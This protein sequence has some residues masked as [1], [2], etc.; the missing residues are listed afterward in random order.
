MI[1]RLKQLIWY[2]CSKCCYCTIVAVPRT[3]SAHPINQ[4][5]YSCPDAPFQNSEL[6]LFVYNRP[7]NFYSAAIAFAVVY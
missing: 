2:K 5:H 6:A 1:D 3:Q 7:R 4:I